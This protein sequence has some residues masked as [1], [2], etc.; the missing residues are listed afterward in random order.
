M[1]LWPSKL[2]KDSGHD[3]TSLKRSYGVSK[4]PNLPDTK[5]VTPWRT[6]LTSVLEKGS[7]KRKMSPMFPKKPCGHTRL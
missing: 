6:E 1:A 7:A 2:N 3:G 5:T 4:S